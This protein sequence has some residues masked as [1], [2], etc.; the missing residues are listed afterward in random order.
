LDLTNDGIEYAALE[1]DN[2]ENVR[3]AGDGRV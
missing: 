3:A 1:R 2:A